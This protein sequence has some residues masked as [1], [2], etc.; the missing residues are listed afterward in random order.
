[1]V[2]HQRDL[3]KGSTLQTEWEREKRWARK[4]EEES[5]IIFYLLC[6][7]GVYVWRCMSAAFPLRLFSVVEE[8]ATKAHLIE[9]TGKWMMESEWTG[10]WPKQVSV[11]TRHM[12]QLP[13]KVLKIKCWMSQIMFLFFTTVKSL[14]DL[15]KG[16]SLLWYWI[17]SL[18]ALEDVIMLR[19]LYL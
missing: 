13:R 9:M 17:I 5:V 10:L 18:T 19:T 3:E 2:V 7:R 8:N 4:V 15:S 11:W 12:K 16:R 6:F 14:A 1:M